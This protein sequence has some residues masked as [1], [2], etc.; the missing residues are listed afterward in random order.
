MHH[1]LRPEGLRLA[2]L[3][4]AQALCLQRQACRGTNS[5]V[6]AILQAQGP[7]AVQLTG[8]EQLQYA[9][10]GWSLTPA[11]THGRQRCSLT[12]SYPLAAVSNQVLS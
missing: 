3:Q 9:C 8:V 4:Q 2:C 10:T 5:D 11:N 12:P 7:P 1:E 6:S